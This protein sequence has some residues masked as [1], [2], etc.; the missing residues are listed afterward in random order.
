MATPNANQPTPTQLETLETQEAVKAIEEV[1][2][3]PD[4]TKI[5]IEPVPSKPNIIII[6]DPGA[7]KTRLA[8]ICPHPLFI[9]Y[10]NGAASAVPPERRIYL[11]IGKPMLEI[12]RSLLAMLITMPYKDKHLTV[13][14]AAIKSL[15]PAYDPMGKEEIKVGCIVFDSIDAL[16]AITKQYGILE[17][18][19]FNPAYQ[20]AAQMGQENW[21][22]L[23]DVMQRIVFDCQKLKIP[24]VMI[25]HVKVV[26]PIFNSD[27]TVKGQGSRNFSAQGSIEDQIKR[28]FDY[29]LHLYVDEN[30]KRTLLTQPTIYHN[31]R[32]VAKDRHAIFKQLM[33]TQFP[34]EAD[35]KGFPATKAMAAIFDNHKY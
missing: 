19:K 14:T 12:T 4:A 33:H 13:K 9:D 3:K 35:K 11:E 30:E 22:T 2:T 27:G 25:A 24:M 20:I 34:I 15:V 31:Y 7:G 6:G 1:A 32:I 16:Q 5:V 26:E 10:E 21:G 23:L 8:A 17:H 29:I 18:K 28:W